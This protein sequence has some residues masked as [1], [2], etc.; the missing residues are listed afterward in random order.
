MACTRT[1]NYRGFNVTVLSAERQTAGLPPARQFEGRFSV[2][3]GSES[4]VAWGESDHVGFDTRVHAAMNARRAAR[5][6][7]DAYLLSLSR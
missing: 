2:V 5:R 7:I 1:H 3:S 4:S 6:S